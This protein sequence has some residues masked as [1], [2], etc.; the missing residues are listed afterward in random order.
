MEP[1]QYRTFATI[2]LGA[3]RQNFQ[4][5]RQKVGPRC[6]ILSVIKA[7]GY[8]HGALAVADVLHAEGCAAFAVSCPTGA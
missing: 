4:I 2:D 3:I 6:K 7:D 1:S 8:G 5:I